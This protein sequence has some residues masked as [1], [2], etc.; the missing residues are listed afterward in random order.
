MVT[1]EADDAL[2]LC[3]YNLLDDLRLDLMRGAATALLS[4]CGTGEVFL[5]VIPA[6]ASHMVHLVP[7]VTAEDEAG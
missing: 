3:Q 7:T 2:E 1:C 5:A 6:F 4:V